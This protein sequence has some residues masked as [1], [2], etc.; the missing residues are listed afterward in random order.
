MIPVGVE[1][2]RDRGERDLTNEQKAMCRDD[3]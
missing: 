2:W 1:K 3:P